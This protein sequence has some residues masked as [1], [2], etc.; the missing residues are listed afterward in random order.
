[1]KST[2]VL[3]DD[4]VLKKTVVSRLGDGGYQRN[5]VSEKKIEGIVNAAKSGTLIPP[6]LLGEVNGELHKE[7]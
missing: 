7:A 4:A 5:I 6:V 1:M 2:M 3:I